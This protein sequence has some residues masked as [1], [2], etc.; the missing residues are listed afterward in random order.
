MAEIDDATLQK[1]VQQIIGPVPG[2]FVPKLA[3]VAKQ[4]IGARFIVAPSRR[5]LPGGSPPPDE[6]MKTLHRVPMPAGVTG[7]SAIN[8]VVSKSPYLDPIH[9]V[10]NARFLTAERIGQL[11]Q[12]VKNNPPLPDAIHIFNRVGVLLLQRLA[13]AVS[14]LG[15]GTVD[16]PNH[17][18]GEI[19]LLAN[20]Y[21]TGSALRQAEKR[22]KVDYLILL[23]EML[24]TWE[25]TNGPDLAYG[26]TRA[27]GML[28]VHLLGDDPI[29]SE[30]RSKLPLDFSE[31]KFDGL[32]IDDYVGCI[33]GMYSWY[34]TL[35]AQQLVDG[36]LNCVI[37][38][39]GF[40]GKTHFPKALFDGF[41]DARSK[42]ID[43]F[44]SLVS[45][46]AITT[47][48]QLGAKLASDLFIADTIAI[49]NYPL[50]RLDATHLVCLDT[51]FLSELLIYGLYWRILGA[52]TKK[53]DGDLFLSLWGRLFELY[54]SEHLLFHYPSAMSP[55]RVDVS[56]DGGQVDALLDFGE[57][58]V[59]FEFKGSLL[60]AQA[61]YNR[62][63]QAFKDDFWLKFVEN[64]KG[65]P[66]ALRQLA[67][68]CAAA[69]SGKLKSTMT[70]KRIFPVFVGYDAVLDGFWVNRYADDI[71]KN[72]LV[73]GLR[74]PVRPLT[75]MSVESLE[76]LLPYTSAGDVTWTDFLARRFFDDQVVDYSVSQAIYD[77]RAEK[78]IEVRRNA[79]IL[80]Q[81]ESIFQKALAK[82]KADP[83]PEVA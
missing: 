42:T 45:A 74:G 65:E 36:T 24:P 43:E 68:S 32:P 11:Q 51:R 40:L 60:K 31:A 26:L 8:L 58:L 29:V 15:Q 20:D 80:K 54:L 22:D 23:I 37:D 69:A 39:S 79:L 14:S 7:L 73:A 47:G 21:V 67:S 13:L 70:P 55:L 53:D 62:D 34:E 28:Q 52:L 81:F 64:E 9:K 78:K 12:F 27:Y 49:R 72:H 4:K 83:E 3:Q 16:E 59:L 18:L 71:F 63:A 41:V 17:L 76:S 50:C 75:V 25:I 10:L 1:I 2:L 56:Y 66:K 57:D 30:L 77:W 19:A 5:E 33:F 44:R 48:D 6:F 82:Y 61:K 46:E 38:T 35:D